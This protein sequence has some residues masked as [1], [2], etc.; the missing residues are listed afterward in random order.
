M[1]IINEINNLHIT[2]KALLLNLFL[3]PFWYIAIYLFNDDFYHN[4]DIIIIVVFSLV[5][6]VIS[7]MSVAYLF[8]L[9]GDLD[10]EKSK[11]TDD[12]KSLTKKEIK[13]RK[14]LDNK[15]LFDDTLRSVFVL[16]VLMSIMIF[17]FYSLKYYCDFLIDFYYFIVINFSI[18]LL[19]LIIILTQKWRRKRKQKKKR[20]SKS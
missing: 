13:K 4:A 15:M 3:M 18:I 16:S 12:S 14:T 5:L 9:S 17:V 1:S 8:E 6:S 7:S 20:I 10:I 11:V 19:V 2:L